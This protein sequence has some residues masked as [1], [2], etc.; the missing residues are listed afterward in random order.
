MSAA[1][2]QQDGLDRLKALTQ[3]NECLGRA[4]FHA[5]LDGASRC[6]LRKVGTHLTSA[7]FQLQRRAW[8]DA[9]L[10]RRK[11]ITCFLE[12]S[13]E[14]AFI[15]QVLQPLFQQL[16]FLRVTVTGHSD[17]LL[18]YGKDMW[19]KY[20]LPTSHYLYF[21]VQAKRTKIDSTGTSKNN[22][23]E[24]LNQIDMMLGHE[25]FD[26]ETN[27][28]VLVDHV[29][30]ISAAEITKPAR[31]WLGQRLDQGKRRSVMFM[32]RDDLLDLAVSTNLKVSPETS[33]DDNVPF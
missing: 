14:D 18:E 16:G 25:I 5:Y 21:G 13:S 33:A 8:T 12:T 17:K 23:A 32:D 22:V 15:E 9:E 30:I 28:Q 4:S 3:L 26:P 27:T 19:M 10:E 1:Y 29:F 20:Q 24:I 11:A 2:F 6:H 7:V 31:N